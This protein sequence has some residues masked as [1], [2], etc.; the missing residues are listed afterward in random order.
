[1]CVCA[2]G[3]AQGVCFSFLFFVSLVYLLLRLRVVYLYRRG[4]SLVYTAVVGTL[5]SERL[6][7]FC[8]GG[9]VVKQARRSENVRP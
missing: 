9:G 2:R 7:F 8:A 4:D 1:M 3:N 5:Q 6:F